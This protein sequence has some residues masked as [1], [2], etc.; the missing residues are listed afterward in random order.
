MWTV[1]LVAERREEDAET[2]S[3]DDET[4]ELFRSTLWHSPTDYE[5]GDIRLVINAV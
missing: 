1:V 2:K 3:V 4:T 5:L